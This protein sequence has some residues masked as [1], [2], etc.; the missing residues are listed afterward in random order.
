MEKVLIA[1]RLSFKKVTI[2]PSDQMLKIF[3]TICNVPVD[4]VEVTDL[5]PHSADSN[6]IVYVKL[7]RK[8]EYHGQVL[9]EHVRPMSLERLLRFLKENNPLYCNIV[10]K[11]EKNTPTSFTV[12]CL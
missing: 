1:K 5:L 3:G 7:K 8:L 10:V 12:K 9:F 4:T 11:T 2:M 6:G